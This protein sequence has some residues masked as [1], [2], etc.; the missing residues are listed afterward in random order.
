MDGY[1]VGTEADTKATDS[2]GRWSVI[3]LLKYIAASV[4]TLA[5]GAAN[6]IVQGSQGAVTN[7]SGTIT[8]G[9]TAQTL[10][11]ANASRKYLFI[12]NLDESEDL[13]FNFTTT[14]VATQPSIKIKANGSFTMEGTF[15][16]TE[17]I[18]VIAA[19]TGHAFAAKEG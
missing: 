7:K 14:A 11:A 19:T 16:S 1:S 2:T 9:A 8:A 13:W 6:V 3:A 5:G 17:L 12:E 4:A 15:I 10:A 18:S